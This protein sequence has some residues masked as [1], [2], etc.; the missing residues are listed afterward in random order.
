M[1][2]YVV[3]DACYGS[4]AASLAAFRLSWVGGLR[5][6]T[7]YTF[8]QR[9]ITILYWPLNTYSFWTALIKQ[10]L[11]PAQIFFCV[12]YFYSVIKFCRCL[13]PV[14]LTAQQHLRKFF[15]LNEN[16]MQVNIY[17]QVDCFIQV[18]GWSEKKKVN[19]TEGKTLTPANM[20]Y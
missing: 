13:T 19:L 2:T 16:K 15:S 8:M 7:N 12:M 10:T 14:S 18:R 4:L 3:I 1:M 5:R 6:E 11:N 20:S 17:R 9:K